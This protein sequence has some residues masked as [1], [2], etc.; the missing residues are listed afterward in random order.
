MYERSFV[1]LIGDGDENVLVFY[2]AQCVVAK[3]M[4]CGL[5]F[6]KGALREKSLIQG[7]LITPLSIAV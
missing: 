7:A 4:H 1:C 5:S 6:S 2:G 3:S